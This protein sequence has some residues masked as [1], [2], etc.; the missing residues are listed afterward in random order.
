MQYAHPHSHTPTSTGTVHRVR[1]LRVRPFS[2]TQPCTQPH[3]VFEG[4]TTS[5]IGERRREE[6]IEGVRDL[7]H[8]AMKFA[9]GCNNNINL[10]YI[11]TKNNPIYFNDFLLQ[12]E[13]KP[14]LYT[15]SLVVKSSAHF[16]TR[17]GK[18]STS[19]NDAKR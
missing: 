6:G 11:T 17:S 19:T 1:G 5:V 14:T 18:A 8:S 16:K 12:S 10:I 2:M 13:K 15:N 4:W 3:P 9:L 7:Q